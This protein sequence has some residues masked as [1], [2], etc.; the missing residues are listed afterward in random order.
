MHRWDLTPKEAVALQEKLRTQVRATG[1]PRSVRRVAG[2]DVSYSRKTNRLY[3]GVVVVDVVD[4]GEVVEAGHA[5]QEAA[6]P[7]VPGL[8]SFRESPAVIAAFERLSFRPDVLI[9]DG[10]GLA[11][12]RG[13]GI[14]SHLGVL[15]DLP[16]IGCAKSLLCGECAD[17]PDRRGATAPLMLD[18]RMVGV[19]LRTREGVK[20]VYVSVGH[21]ISLRAAADTVL[22][23]TRGYRLP[24]PT[25]LAHQL[26]NKLRTED[27][28]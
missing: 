17:P 2:S 15:L 7:Y 26:V 16:T 14:A 5:I 23:M 4:C 13:F 9:V 21:R 18:G 24:E 12:P 22:D 20:P 25:R 1:G 8:L 10:Q 11:H 27:G 19:A 3:A 6:F 28:G